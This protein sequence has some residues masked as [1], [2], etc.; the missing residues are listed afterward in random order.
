[1]VENAFGIA[2]S[3]FRVFRRSICAKVETALDIAKVVIILHNFL[4]A[5]RKFSHNRYFDETLLNRNDLPDNSAFINI[6]Q[7]G[8]NKLYRRYQ[9]NTRGSV[10][11]RSVP[12]KYR[13]VTR[14]HHD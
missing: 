2:T 5:D 13:M 10:Q 8:S 6:T 12:C 14:T 4:M 9:A 7:A 3:R 1:M 11:T